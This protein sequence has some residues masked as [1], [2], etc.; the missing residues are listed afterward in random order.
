MYWIPRV[1]IPSNRKIFFLYTE[2]FN[3]DLTPICHLTD[4]FC[5][6]L[7]TSWKGNRF[8][9]IRE[10]GCAQIN[11]RTRPSERKNLKILVAP[12][13]N[14]IDARTGSFDICDQLP[15]QVRL[16]GTKNNFIF[17]T[18]SNISFLHNKNKYLSCSIKS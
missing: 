18:F 16:K 15:A 8:I 9:D 13:R 7:H 6:K 4:K 12:V 14:R 10:V 2:G 1:S 11:S 5:F 17:P 3:Q